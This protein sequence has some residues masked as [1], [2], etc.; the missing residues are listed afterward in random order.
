MSPIVHPL[1]PKP[2]ALVGAPILRGVER[3]CTPPGLRAR[4]SDSSGAE[5]AL[6]VGQLYVRRQTLQQPAP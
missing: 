4:R 1:P 2:A 6:A 5:K 3:P